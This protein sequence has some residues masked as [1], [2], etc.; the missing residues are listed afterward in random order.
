MLFTDE[1][2]A[3]V[4]SPVHCFWGEDDPNGGAET[5]KRFVARLPQAT[6]ELV[7]GAGHVPWI[8]EPDRALSSTR[9]FLNG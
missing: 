2:L 6:L 4:S 8:D 5:A 1:E 7:A 9:A 3:R